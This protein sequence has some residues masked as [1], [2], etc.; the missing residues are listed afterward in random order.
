MA[1]RTP[2][3]SAHAHPRPQSR[4]RAQ[5]RELQRGALKT[6]VVVSG[7]IVNESA[8]AITVKRAEGATDAI[9]RD[10][11][12]AISST[13]I[14]LMPEG[15]EKGLAPVDFANLIAFI[16]SIQTPTVTG[17]APAAAK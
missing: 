2:G 9:T 12:E 8:T 3:R 5:F 6:A 13:G 7:I 11:I 15:L 16:R 4:S 10:Q 14:S 17:R 1:T